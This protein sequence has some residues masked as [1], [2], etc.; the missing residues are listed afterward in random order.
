MLHHWQITNP[1]VRD[2]FTFHFS[3]FTSSICGF[4]RTTVLYFFSMVWASPIYDEL[5]KLHMLLL[6]LLAHFSR[7]S[8]HLIVFIT[9]VGP[10]NQRFEN[11]WIIELVGN[12]LILF[13]WNWNFFVKSIID[14]KKVSWNNTVRLINNTLILKSVIEPWIVVKINRIVK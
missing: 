6:L 8:L 14:K 13:Y 9:L 12:L 1:T 5:N 10:H 11:C 7:F 4:F 3:L 2:V